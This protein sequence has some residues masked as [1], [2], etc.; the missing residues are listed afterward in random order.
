MLKF[1]F[2]LCACVVENKRDCTGE[3]QAWL[4]RPNEVTVRGETRKG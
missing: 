4:C 3:V 1:L 2:Y